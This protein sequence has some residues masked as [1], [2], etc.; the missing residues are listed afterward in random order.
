MGG[1]SSRV[2]PPGVDAHKD[3]YEGSRWPLSVEE[4]GKR[5]AEGAAFF[6]RGGSDG[7]RSGWS[8]GL[9]VGA[10]GG[11]FSTATDLLNHVVRGTDTILGFL[12]LGQVLRR[13]QVHGL[14]QLP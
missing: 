2:W 12:V 7:R 3:V 9:A 5:D 8:G 13:Q 10:D 14:L 1:W 11:G 4:P 6:R